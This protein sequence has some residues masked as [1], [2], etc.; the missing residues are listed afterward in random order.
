MVS[1]PKDKVPRQWSFFLFFLDLSSFCRQ[2]VP[3]GTFTFFWGLCTFGTTT[4]CFFLRFFNGKLITINMN[5]ICCSLWCLHAR[6]PG[7]AHHTCWISNQERLLW[8][9]TLL[10]WFHPM[11]R[12]HIYKPCLYMYFQFLYVFL[13]FRCIFNP[14]CITCILGYMSV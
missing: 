2:H 12:S 8:S 6:I 11:I 13:I 10:T 4:G 1:W 9:A 3:C 7:S 14:A 5:F